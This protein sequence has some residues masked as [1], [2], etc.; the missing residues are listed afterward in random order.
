M[1]GILPPSLLQAVFFALKGSVIIWTRWLFKYVGV[2]QAY[3]T[4]LI[5]ATA[6]MLRDID[7][8]RLSHI[9]GANRAVDMR[10]IFLLQMRDCTSP[11]V[12]LIARYIK[13]AGGTVEY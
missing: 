1:A 9:D 11:S 10:N 2:Y 8:G 5:T 12:L 3:R 7:G 6:K 4:S 13:P